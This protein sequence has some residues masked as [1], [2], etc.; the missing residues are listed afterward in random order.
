MN[1]KSWEKKTISTEIYVE[2]WVESQPA[3]K[4]WNIVLE[5]RAQYFVSFFCLKWPMA[6][7]ICHRDQTRNREKGFKQFR[8]MFL[9]GGG[10]SE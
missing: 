10:T 5:I 3:Q 1:L 2:H 9:E 8:D 4:K 6:W 7:E